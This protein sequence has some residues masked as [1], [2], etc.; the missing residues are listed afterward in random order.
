[1]KKGRH[2]RY[3]EARA[4]KRNQDLDIDEIFESLEATRGSV[5]NEGYSPAFEAGAEEFPSDQDPI[6]EDLEVGA[7]ESVEHQE[8]RA[9]E[10]EESGRTG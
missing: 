7:S 8:P 9:S 5:S 6:D 10:I 2:R 3:E 4:L 1:M